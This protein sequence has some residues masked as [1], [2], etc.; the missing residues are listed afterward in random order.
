MT[1]FV[2]CGEALDE[3]DD[4]K[5]GSLRPPLR[6][7]GGGLSSL[8][9]LGPGWLPIELWSSEGNGTNSEE[10]AGFLCCLDVLR[11]VF[12]AKLEISEGRDGDDCT[13]KS[14]I[15]ALLDIAEACQARKITLGLG[16]EHAGNAELFCSLLYLGF[17]VAPSPKSPLSDNA[18]LLLDFDLGLPMYQ[19]LVVSDHTCTAT[20]ECS[21][22]AEDDC[23]LD[24]TDVEDTD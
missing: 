2:P 23:P 20:S 12:Y 19:D 3:G 21:T 7:R 16:P 4:D 11:K 5:D 17:Q 1:G 24:Q 15:S 14:A 8:L 10:G 22:S 18:V 9:Q 6:S 13:C